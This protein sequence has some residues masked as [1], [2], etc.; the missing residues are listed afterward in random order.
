MSP[1][2]LAHIEE[3]YEAMSRHDIDALRALGERY[4]DHRWRNA[5][6][7]PETGERVGAA[8]AIA[9]VEELFAT[10]DRIETEVVEV[11]E[12]GP[13]EVIFAV[14]HRVRGARSGAWG[15]RD[16][17]HLWRARDGR[18]VSMEEFVSVE[19]ARAAAGDR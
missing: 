13:D 8:S 6:D 3:L 14:R 11:I 7:V 12:L 18:I 19:E 5:P 9:Y 16:E 10:V 2:N 4:P 1:E 15:E 17:A